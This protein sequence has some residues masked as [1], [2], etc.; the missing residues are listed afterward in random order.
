[1]KNKEMGLRSRVLEQAADFNSFNCPTVDIRS[2][3]DED[4][5]GLY[6]NRACSVT[7][8]SVWFV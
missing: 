7:D 8:V 4:V 1:M 6:V 5:V 2:I 3:L